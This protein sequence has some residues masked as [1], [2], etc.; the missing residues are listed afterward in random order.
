MAIKTL[1]QLEAEFKKH[2]QVGRAMREN[3]DDIQ[4]KKQL[5]KL[6]KKYEG[7]FWKYK[8]SSGSED[9]W[10]LYSH[11][12]KVVDERGGMFDSFETTTYQSNFKI[13][14][15]DYYHLCEV[16]ITKEEYQKAL[17]DFRS[18]FGALEKI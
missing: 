8:N 12:R 16:E 13:N 18:L 6:K 10:W 17:A 11:C 14:N 15:E 4:L 9:K 7:K 1:K 5:P 2:C 3:I